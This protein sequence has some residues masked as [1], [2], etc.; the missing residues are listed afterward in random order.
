MKTYQFLFL[1]ALL[2][3]IY[4]RLSPATMSGTLDIVAC[5]IGISGAF[6]LFKGI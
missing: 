5:S 2:L 3:R 1:S 6:A 4:S